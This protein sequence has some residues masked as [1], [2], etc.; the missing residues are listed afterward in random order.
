VITKVSIYQGKD[1]KHLG[2]EAA[3]ATGTFISLARCQPIRVRS[4]TAVL[5]EI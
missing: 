4:W 2:T 1:L 3:K 5:I